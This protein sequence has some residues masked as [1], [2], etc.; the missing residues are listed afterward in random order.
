MKI[1]DSIKMLAESLFRWVP[2]PVETG[3][4]VF[5][6][7]DENSPVFLTSNYDLTVKRV[8]KGLL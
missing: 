3:L 1:K 7:P 8:S 5:G 2:F 4:R 6:N